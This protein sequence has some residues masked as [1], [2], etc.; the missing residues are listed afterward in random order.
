MRNLTCL[1]VAGAALASASLPAAA[2]WYGGSYRYNAPPPP[3]GYGGPSYSRPLPR[4]V[5][6]DRLEERGFEDVGRPRL[7]EGVYIVEATSRRSGAV[8]V[9]LDAYDGRILRQIPLSA[10]RVDPLDDEF[11]GYARPRR[12]GYPPPEMPNASRWRPGEPEPLPREAGRPVEPDI[13]TP[14]PTPRGR[15]NDPRLAPSEEP[16]GAGRAAAPELRREAARPVNP[17]TALP[18]GEVQGLNP[19][20][21]RAARPAP[22][23]PGEAAVKPDRPVEQPL[24]PPARTS[25]PAPAPSTASRPDGA[26][27]VAPGPSTAQSGE[28]K[29]VRVIEGVTPLNSGQQSTPAPQNNVETSQKPAQPSQN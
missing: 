7:E 18:P 6:V 25:P 26:K 8:R 1:L 24:P 29:P 13:I 20:G 23:P 22:K 2:Q 9:V 15:P 10:A 19:D 3:Y 12:G 4:D 14:A 11:D 16:S 27:P 5:I 28:R 17:E 21:R